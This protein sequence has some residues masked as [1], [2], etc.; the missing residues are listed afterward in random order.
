MPVKAK[1]KRE[2]ERAKILISTPKQLEFSA[3]SNHWYKVLEVGDVYS[4]K[5]GKTEITPEYLEGVVANFKANANETVPF[6]DEMHNRGISFGPISDMKFEDNALF[7]H[8]DWNELGTK[9]VN[10]KQFM[11]LSVDIRPHKNSNTGKTVFPVLKGVAVCNDP[12]FKNQEVLVASEGVS[13]DN[14]TQEDPATSDSG[15]IDKNPK[16]ESTMDKVQELL[17]ELADA[18]K[19]VMEGPDA[20]TAKQSIHDAIESLEEAIGMPDADNETETP[21][22]EKTEVINPEA[23]KADET[24][25]EVPV[26]EEA[27]VAEKKGKTTIQT[28]KDGVKVTHEHTP[29]APIKAEDTQMSELQKSMTQFAEDNKN[30]NAKVL[31]L[32]EENMNYK[33]DLK[34][35]EFTSTYVGKKI[36]PAKAEAYFS[37]FCMDEESTKTILEGMPT[38]K[39]GEIGTDQDVKGKT[40]T[41]KIDAENEL[42]AKAVAIQADKKIKFSDAVALASQE[43]PEI[44][45]AM[46]ELE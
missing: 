23:P 35:A 19:V 25:M 18:I 38:I 21:A 17:N 5:Y 43:N 3:E 30:L 9:T 11:Y 24:Q 40:F 31:L 8:I 45:K 14:N 6:V 32:T 34:K 7:V 1:E 16:E 26:K 15:T 12:I 41:T 44:V 2:L 10:D 29:E 27:P 22:E 42:N 20:E 33:K 28:T 37:L 36:H 46:N 4:N 13:T 39:L